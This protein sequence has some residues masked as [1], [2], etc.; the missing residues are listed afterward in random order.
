MHPSKMSLHW[1]VESDGGGGS[2]CGGG[3]TD[4]SE[5]PGKSQCIKVITK[6]WLTIDV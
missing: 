4:Y 5:Q 2:G 3:I 6:Q 1:C